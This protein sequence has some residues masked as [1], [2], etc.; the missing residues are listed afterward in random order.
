MTRPGISIFSG[1]GGLD[2]GLEKSADVEFRAWVEYDDSAVQTLQANFPIGRNQVF[3]DARQVQP[4]EAMKAAGLGRGETFVLAGGPPC[5]AFSTAGHRLSLEDPRGNLVKSYFRFVDSVRPRFF[6]FENVRGL[7]SAAVRH[8]P[9]R[10]RGKESGALHDDEQLGSVLGRVVLPGFERLGYE[11]MYGLLDAADYGVPQRRHRVVIIGSRDGELRSQDF[12]ATH[13][14]RLMTTDLVRATHENPA[15]RRD[16]SLLDTPARLQPWRLLKDAL[17][18]LTDAAETCLSYSPRRRDVYKHIPAGGNWRFIRDNPSLFPP[19]F[20]E[21][22][23]GGALLASGGRVGFWRRLSW[24]EPSPTVVTSPVQKAT[25]LCHPEETRPL[26]VQEYKRV[27]EFPDDFHIAGSVADKYRQI[28]NAVPV[29]LA[30]AIG[31]TLN[32]IANGGAT[33]DRQTSPSQ[34]LTLAAPFRH[35]ALS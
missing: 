28:G 1:A 32:L 9:L 5:Q 17:H 21:E 12:Q 16:P 18:N 27:Q 11:V 10:L 3:R 8:R 30:A 2:F 19:G 31:R 4:E 14:R 15:S 24:D 22:V 35:V 26:S 13:G 23:M 25:G 34:D 7:L 29:G 6:V 33:N 20:L